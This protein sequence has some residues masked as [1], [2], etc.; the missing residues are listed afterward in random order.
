RLVH[1][2][3]NEPP[4]R[5]ERRRV[6]LP[7]VPAD[8]G[9]VTRVKI[10][11]VVE[12]DGRRGADRRQRLQQQRRQLLGQLFIIARSLADSGE[13]PDVLEPASGFGQTVDLRVVLIERELLDYVLA[14][15]VGLGNQKLRL[16]DQK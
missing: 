2:G 14:V 9:T 8:H 10:G 11:G 16:S 1:C 12:A 5:R 15:V 3:A 13:T 6:A 4:A 7:A